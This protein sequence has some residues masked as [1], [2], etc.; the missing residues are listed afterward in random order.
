MKVKRGT[1]C[2]QAGSSM[3]VTRKDLSGE[4]PSDLK[5][6]RGLELSEVNKRY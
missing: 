1:L 2:S 3:G 6:Y 5:S 4:M